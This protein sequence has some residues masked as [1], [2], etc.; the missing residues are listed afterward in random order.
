MSTQNGAVGNPWNPILRRFLRRLGG[1]VGAVF[2][3]LC[4]A[5]VILLV[6]DLL[7]AEGVSGLVGYLLLPYFW[8][9]DWLESTNRL[10]LNSI[11]IVAWG[12]PVRC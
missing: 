8:F 6:S 11:I 12:C 1:V 5:F 4:L 9:A 3:Y 10:A 2:F 7:E